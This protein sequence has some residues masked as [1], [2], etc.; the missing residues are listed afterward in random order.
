[1]AAMDL[2]GRR[3]AL[4]ILWELRDGAV[5][6]RELLARCDGLS[7]SVLYTRLGELADAGLV[8]NAEDG[9]ALTDLGASLRTALD[10]LDAWATAWAAAPGRPAQP[11]PQRRK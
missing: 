2:L 9:Y 5:G 8:V 7:S 3:W 10:P 1:M 6:P 4:R 11:R